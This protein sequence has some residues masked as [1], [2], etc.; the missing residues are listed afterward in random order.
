MITI[1]DAIHGAISVPDQIARF[2]NTP[3]FQRLRNIKQLGAAVFQFP[4]ATHTR[5]EHSLG[6]YHLSRSLAS[7]FKKYQ[8]ELDITERDVRCVAIAGLCHDLGHG[9]FSHLFDQLVMP[10]LGM[11][12][13]THEIASQSMFDYLIDDN[14]IDIE[15]D[16]IL[17]IKDLITGT[18]KSTSQRDEKQ[19]LFDIVA[20]KTNGLDVD[21]AD[22]LAR[23]TYYLKGHD[24]KNMDFRDDLWKLDCIWLQRPKFEVRD[25][26]ICFDDKLALPAIYQVFD[27]RRYLFEHV[28]TE[29]KVR[30]IDH[31]VKDALVLSNNTLSIKERSQD[32]SSYLYLTDHI[33]HEI[34]IST[35]Q[36]HDMIKARK[37]IHELKV[38]RYYSLL[39][40][41][42]LPYDHGYLQPSSDLP[43]D[44][45][46]DVIHFDHG[47]KDKNP[48]DLITFY[49]TE[50]TDE[51]VWESKQLHGTDFDF[52]Y[53]YTNTRTY[54]R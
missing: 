25:N 39:E 4:S 36:Q 43:S 35:S 16:D 42:E 47:F 1:P 5:Y 9:P 37:I 30:A 27:H 45:I 51:Q 32:M 54:V 6:T 52:P 46:R 28:Y 11:P 19:F 17:F 44:T 21:K 31:M 13:W 49:P 34:E 8:R 2:I 50:F 22:Y 38:G 23:D 24:P 3:Q 26:H 29:P 10:A 20:N 48:K 18:P 33:L 53:N 14:S 12:N 41:Q 40:E 7:H 15:A